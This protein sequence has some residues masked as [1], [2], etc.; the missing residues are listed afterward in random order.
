[1]WAERGISRLFFNIVPTGIDAFVPP[2]HELEALLLV[3][4]RERK[5]IILGGP[6]EQ[7]KNFHFNYSQRIS[8]DPVLGGKKGR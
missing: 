4:G 8:E 7:G 6:L 1:M 3:K 2:L 5:E